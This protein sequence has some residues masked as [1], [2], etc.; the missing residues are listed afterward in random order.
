MLHILLLAKN[1]AANLPTSP[2]DKSLPFE[3]A[4]VLAGVIIGVALTVMPTKR[5]SEIKKQ[6]ED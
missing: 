1:S 4:L 5:T 3:W 6:K 2:A